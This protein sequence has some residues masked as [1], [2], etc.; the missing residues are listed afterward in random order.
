MVTL[1]YWHYFLR[2][3]DMLLAYLQW[4]SK[5]DSLFDRARD[6]V[7]IQTRL[8]KILE[9]RP[10][11]SL[12]DY[13]TNEVPKLVILKLYLSD[14]SFPCTLHMFCIEISFLKINKCIFSNR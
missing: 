1:I 7:P 11:L 4:Q 8:E 14:V 13:K 6:I 10:V 12:T 5:V 9:P 3:Q 2:L